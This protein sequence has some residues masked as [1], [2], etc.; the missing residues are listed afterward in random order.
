MWK[1]TIRRWTAHKQTVLIML[2]IMLDGAV[3]QKTSPL[4]F[5]TMDG[6]ILHIGMEPDGDGMAGMGLVGDGIPGMDGDGI[7]GMDGADTILHIGADIILI[8]ITIMV[9]VPVI[10]ETSLILTDVAAEL[11]IQA[12]GQAEEIILLIIIQTQEIHIQQGIAVLPGETTIR[13]TDLQLIA[14]EILAGTM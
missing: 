14:Q 12:E 10:P 7:P 3:I 5:M 2:V 1:T 13:A 9:A 6:V 4:T 8:I 11:D